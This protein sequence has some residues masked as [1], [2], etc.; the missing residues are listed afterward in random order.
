MT[1]ELTREQRKLKASESE[2]LRQSVQDWASE[3]ALKDL[4]FAGDEPWK[5]MTCDQRQHLTKALIFYAQNAA[6]RTFDALKLR[7]DLKP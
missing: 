5:G 4:E 3:A 2:K 7:G 1:T 6:A